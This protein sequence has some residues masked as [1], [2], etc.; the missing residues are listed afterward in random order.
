MQDGK[1]SIV[2]YY[3]IIIQDFFKRKIGEFN[4]FLF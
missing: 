2:A 1:I 4:V 3:E